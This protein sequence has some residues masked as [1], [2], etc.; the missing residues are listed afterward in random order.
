MEALE[1]AFVIAFAER[2]LI[3]RVVRRNSNGRRSGY[4]TNSIPIPQSNFASHRAGSRVFHSGHTV[5]RCSPVWVSYRHHQ[6][7]GVG[8]GQ[9]PRRPYV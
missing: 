8:R 2:R 1:K 9:F 7:W 4:T 6:H 3:G 5:K